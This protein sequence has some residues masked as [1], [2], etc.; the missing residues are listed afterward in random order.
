MGVKKYTARG[1][2]YWEIDT[3]L[4]TGGR[5]KRFRKRS[6]PTKE[7]AKAS[8]SVIDGGRAD[9]FFAIIGTN[10]AQRARLGQEVAEDHGDQRDLFERA[11]GP[12]QVQPLGDRRRKLDQLRRHVEQEVA[13]D[14]KE[15]RVVAEGV[16][17]HRV[18]DVPRSAEVEV[19]AIA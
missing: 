2:T 18:D 11:L 3:Y 10:L 4:E 12:R 13:G 7:M 16:A 1:A 17:D 8:T 6:I 9:R 19:S 14:E 15:D 5:R